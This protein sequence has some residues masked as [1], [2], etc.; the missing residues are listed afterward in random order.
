M[1]NPDR[2]RKYT[3]SAVIPGISGACWTR[4]VASLGG[5]KLKPQPSPILL[6]HHVL[7]WCAMKKCKRGQMGAMTVNLLSFEI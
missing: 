7:H 2:S 1:K 5:R 3:S 4:M 6:G